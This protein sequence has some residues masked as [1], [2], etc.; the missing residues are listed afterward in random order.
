MGVVALALVAAL[1]LTLL[2]QP[3]AQAGIANQP[4]AQV[5]PNVTS[6]PPTQTTPAPVKDTKPANSPDQEALQAAFLKN[7]AARL[8]VDEAK[9]NSAFSQAVGDTLDQAVKDGQIPAEL[10]TKLKTA[11]Q[12]GPKGLLVIVD[13]LKPGG[14]PVEKFPGQNDLMD[15]AIQAA[16]T[17]LG[18]KSEDF[19][20]GID[21]NKSIVELAAQQ[22]V[23]LQKVKDA[24]LNS[25]K[26]DL[27]ALVK[28]GKLTQ[29]QADEYYR[30]SPAWFDKLANGKSGD[31]G[32]KGS[33][34][35]LTNP[36]GLIVGSLADVAALFKTDEKSLNA[37]LET[38][39]LAAYAQSQNI[40]V[41]K[42]KETMLASFKRQTDDVVKAGKLPQ[43]QADEVYKQASSMA[44]GF[45]NSIPSPNG[46]REVV[47]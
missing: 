23:D 25:I 21:N 2:A 18:L 8:G 3:S 30:D 13:L 31:A 35:D 37:K 17:V 20:K 22:H 27:D 28:S 33:P 41:A 46:G 47:K 29:A 19:K 34:D 6:Q 16:M 24:V 39:S 32:A 14:G 26:T 42:V 7:F 4:V 43:A 38:M 44:D 5:T 10:A 40:D 12:N 36:K 15:H 9:F 45:I 11:A 1:A